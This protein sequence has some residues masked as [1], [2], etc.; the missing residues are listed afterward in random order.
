M[1]EI[2]AG[3]SRTGRESLFNSRAF[4][5]ALPFL[6]LL[7]I[8]LALPWLASGYWGIIAIRACIYWVLAAG[9][10]LMVGFA[11]QLAIGWVAILTLGAYVASVLV[12]RQRDARLAPLSRAP[13]R[14]RRRSHL[15]ADRRTARAAAAHVLFRDHDARLCDDRHADRA[16]LA[17]RHRRRHRRARAAVSGAVRYANGASTISASPLRRSAPG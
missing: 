12:G 8:G 13:D 14:G 15:R 6:V 3:Q 10:N 11:G 2:S 9:L 5:T 16:R 17:E 4:A 1:T 7:V